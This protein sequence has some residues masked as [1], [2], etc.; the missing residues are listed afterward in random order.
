MRTKFAI[1]DDILEQIGHTPLLKLYKRNGVEIYAK[2][3]WF[4]PG[5]SVKDRPA[6]RMIEDGEQSGRLTKGKTILDA[7]SGNVGIAYAMIGAIK[8]YKVLLVMPENVSEERKRMLR[9]YGAEMVLTDPLEE[10][11][12]AILEAH[13]IYE[14]DP[15]NYFYP[16]QYNNPS[17][18]LAHY[19]TTGPEIIEQTRGRVT[20]FVAGIGTG[21][22]IMGAG[23]R[24]K[25][26]NPEIKLIAVE[27]VEPLHG[28]GGLKHM[29]NS[30]V[31]GIYDESFL[32]GKIEVETEEAYEMARRLAKEKGL[33]VGQSSGAALVG[34][35]EVAKRVEKGIIVTVFPDGGDRY[36]TTPLWI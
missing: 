17:N 9:A 24:L 6:L 16:D 7:T 18:P 19:E 29:A 5:G 23:R 31:P 32:D 28:I 12:G 4:N 27:P 36:L 14:S 25:E 33:L 20:H 22:T 35:L 34:A 2:A 11:D 21:G 30:I 13:R 1:R 3:E 15:H 8:G 10:I 26:F